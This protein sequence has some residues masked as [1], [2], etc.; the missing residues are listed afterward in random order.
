MK[1]EIV[2]LNTPE[3]KR[4]IQNLVWNIT[5]T[6]PKLSE[7]KIS[8]SKSFTYIYGRPFLCYDRHHHYPNSKDHSTANFFFLRAI[9]HLLLEKDRREFIHNTLKETK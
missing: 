6:K 8:D 1:D 4:V 5:D 3:N 7:I 9:E 2:K